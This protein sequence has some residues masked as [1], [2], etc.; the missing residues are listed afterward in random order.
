MKKVLVTGANGYI[1]KHV[2]QNLLNQ[3]CD[4]IACDVG[5]DNYPQGC[6]IVETDLFNEAVTFTT[7]CC[8]DIC[9]HLAWQDGFVHN[10]D[11]HML[12]LS[13]HFGLIE[14]LIKGGLKHI[15]VMGSMHEIGYFEGAINENTYCN[16]MS[17]YGIAKNSLRQSVELL[18]KER[19]VVFQWLRG[20]YIYGDDQNSNSIFNKIT[21]ADAK[22]EKTF[23]FTTGKSKFDFI[24]IDEF[25]KQIVNASL[26]DKINGVINCCTGK[27][28][29]LADK[30]EKYITDNN[31]KIKLA[32][33]AYP[34]RPYDSPGI[35]GDSTK[36]ERIM[37]NKNEE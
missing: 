6:K 12:K 18:A 28:I 37:A 3:N 35:W 5:F 19:D 20:F 7:L 23:P 26:Q 24:E 33:G 1:G 17:M 8:P 36:I 31:L 14:K 22:G 11:K 32:Y 25:A 29:S 27:P 15:T 30:V 9:I 10:S 16:P 21:N 13:D 2:I 34:D 4:V